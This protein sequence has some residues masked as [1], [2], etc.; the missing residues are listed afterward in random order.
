M[1]FLTRNKS[2]H[3]YR[4][5]YAKD[6]LKYSENV[7]FSGKGSYLHMFRSFRII[8]GPIFGPVL[9]DNFDFFPGIF[10]W[11]QKY[12][13]GHQTVFHNILFILQNLYW[14]SIII[15]N[16]ENMWVF[17]MINLACTHEKCIKDLKT[18]VS[19]KQFCDPAHLG[20]KS[21]PASWTFLALLPSPQELLIWH[22]GVPKWTMPV[23]FP[24]SISRALSHRTLPS[25]GNRNW[26]LPQ[27][28]EA[29]SDVG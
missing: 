29:V 10:D 17:T 12:W 24:L 28:T 5:K 22:V 11:S 13:T 27:L 1:F 18:P 4:L 8:L 16:K 19:M 23:V 7:H 2:R 6:V 25:P 21:V 20:K 15:W 3:K 9:T 26:L 14:F